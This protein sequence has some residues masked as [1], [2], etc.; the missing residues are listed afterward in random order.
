MQT[1]QL[2]KGYSTIVDDDDF[3]RLSRHKWKAAVGDGVHIYAVRNHKEGGRKGTWKELKMHRIIMNAGDGF[4]VDHI[5]GSTLDNRKSNLRLC[6]SSNNSMNRRGNR[7]CSSRF[8]GVWLSKKYGTWVASIKKEGK[9]TCLGYFDREIDAAL[10]YNI[11]A[12]ELFGEFAYL[13]DPKLLVGAA[14]TKRVHRQDG[15]NNGNSKLKEE[16]VCIIKTSKE[17]TKILAEKYGVSK[18]TIIRIRSNS[19]W[20]KVKGDS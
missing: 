9:K 12:K 19:Q 10:A 16:D 8:K 6:S 2:T 11:A 20:K 7:S 5:N 18:S 13:N 17:E 14:P 4:L 3:E 15:S 1:I